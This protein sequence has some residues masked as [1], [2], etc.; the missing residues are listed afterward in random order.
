MIT[1]LPP[2]IAVD[3]LDANGTNW[4]FFAM[5]HKDA[6]CFTSIAGQEI[7]EARRKMFTVLLFAIPAFVIPFFLGLHPLIYMCAPI[8]TMLIVAL[9]GYKRGTEFIGQTVES[10]IKRDWY[11]IPLEESLLA[12]AK[13]LTSYGQFDGWAVEKILDGLEDAVP[14]AEKWVKSNKGL[15]DKCFKKYG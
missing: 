10:V 11:N 14:A 15:I 9:P 6:N 3:K 7:K 13:Q 12:N 4:P 2:T 5:V 1:I 8:L